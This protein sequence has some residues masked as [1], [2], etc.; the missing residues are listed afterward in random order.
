MQQVVSDK[1]TL[2]N[3]AANV[4]RLRNGKSYSQLAR[5]VSID[6]DRAYPATIERIEK[7]V[8]M[9]GAGLLKRLAEALGTT[10]D[11]LMSD[12]PTTGKR[13]SRAS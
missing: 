13:L 9:P 7:G 12:P 11:A 3:I 2:E 1:T 8:N 6:D 4:A 5:D 10:T